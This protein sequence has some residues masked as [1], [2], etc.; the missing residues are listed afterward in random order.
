M[1][2]ILTNLMTSAVLLIGIGSG[3]EAQSIQMH[4]AVPFAW[5]VDGRQMT[6][7]DYAI[8]SQA[9]SHVIAIQDKT[10]G[11]GTFLLATPI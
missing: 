5:Q 6:A 11:K 4:A 10:N 9:G 3:L 7:G 2:N 1:K 8:S